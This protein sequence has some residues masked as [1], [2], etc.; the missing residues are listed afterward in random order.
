MDDTA[1]QLEAALR[2]EAGR[3]VLLLDFDPQ[4]RR[5]LSDQLTLTDRHNIDEARNGPEALQLLKSK[6]YDAVLVG[7]PGPDT[8]C[9]ELC[10]MLR[11]GNAGT[12][13]ILIW[14]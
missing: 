5:I 1:T 2:D 11:T 6:H 4:A 14:R 9:L 3:D 7:C 13:I 8:D 10:R 12:P